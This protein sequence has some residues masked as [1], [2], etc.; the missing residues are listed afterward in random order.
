MEVAGE[1][2]RASAIGQNQPLPEFNHRY[3]KII[4]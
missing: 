1:E 2:G 4:A 3:A